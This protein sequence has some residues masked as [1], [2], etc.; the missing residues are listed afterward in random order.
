[1]FQSDNNFIVIKCTHFITLDSKNVKS[2]ERYFSL[3]LVLVVQQILCH[4]ANLFVLLHLSHPCFLFLHIYQAF[5][6]AQL[7]LSSLV[8]LRDILDMAHLQH[9]LYH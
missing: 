6:A 4:Q 5:L 3:H 2:Q 7:H 9:L 8:F 1:M